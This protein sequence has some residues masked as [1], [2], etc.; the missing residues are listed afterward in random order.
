MCLFYQSLFRG[1]SDYRS[2]S[3][4]VR[5]KQHSP[6]QTGMEISCPK[7][8]INFRSISPR[9]IKFINN[10]PSFEWV[11][12]FLKKN[13][14]QLHHVQKLE[15]TIVKGVTADVLNEHITRVKAAL[16]HHIINHPEQIF[17]SNQSAVCFAKI[18][19]CSLRKGIRKNGWQLVQKALATKE[20][21]DRVTITSVISRGGTPIILLLYFEK[22]NHTTA[23]FVGRCSY[24]VQSCRSA[25]YFNITLVELTRQ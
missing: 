9:A 19:G 23:K 17:T 13:N 3:C 24:C 5:R 16:K 2:D 6:Y 11:H 12:H 7:L 1:G 4:W 22:R 14:S 15:N 8:S 10:R 20:D 18:K 25:F 21:L